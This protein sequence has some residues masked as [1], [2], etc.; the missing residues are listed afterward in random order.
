MVWSPHQCGN[1]ADRD[2]LQGMYATSWHNT[3]SV[4]EMVSHLGLESLAVRRN[5]MRVYSTVPIK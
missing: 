1:G 4:S 2:V 3:S 5:N